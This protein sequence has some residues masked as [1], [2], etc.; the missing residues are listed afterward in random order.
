MIDLNIENILSFI[1]RIIYKI[2]YS[3]IIN[4]N[5]LSLIHVQ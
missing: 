2:R 1:S 5:K 3:N 4:Y